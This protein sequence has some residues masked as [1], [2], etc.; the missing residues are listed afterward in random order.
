MRS[1]FLSG[2]NSRKQAHRRSGVTGVEGAAC[3]LQS[4]EAA[5]GKAHG[6][7]IDFDFSA[8]RFHA[9]EGAVAIGGGGEVAQLAGAF[10]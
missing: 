3:A 7:F 1:K 4:T 2:K 5:A 6:V 9:I 10:G 8:Q